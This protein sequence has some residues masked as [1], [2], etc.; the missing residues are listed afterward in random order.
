MLEDQDHEDMNGNVEDGEVENKPKRFKSEFYNEPTAG[1]M[2]N[3]K[4][5]ENLY[6]S[7]LFRLQVCPKSLLKLNLQSLDLFITLKLSE[8]IN[9]LNLPELKLKSYN[10]ILK[11]L[12]KALKSLKTLKD[13]K[14][15][16][17]LKTLYANL[18]SYLIFSWV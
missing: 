10:L 5:T 9:E 14:V 1:E 8:L 18:T 11:D 12:I 6:Q 15:K 3:L 4:N 2:Y 17:H 7:N 16:Y 13:L